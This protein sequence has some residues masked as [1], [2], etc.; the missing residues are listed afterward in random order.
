MIRLTVLYG[1][2]TDPDAF[3]RYY[4][5]VHLPIARRMKGLQGWTIGKCT[6]VVPGEKPP[7]YLIV[8]L[9]AADRAAMDAILASPEGQAAI[10]DVPKFATGGATFLYDDEEV[11]IDVRLSRGA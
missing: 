5:D 8:G 11:L 10:A 3:D 6:S 4:R 1:H 7:Y 9:Y 2:P